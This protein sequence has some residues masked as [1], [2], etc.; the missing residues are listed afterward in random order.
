MIGK[1]FRS[2]PFIFANDNYTLSLPPQETGTGAA[3]QKAQAET[4]RAFHIQSVGI[5]EIYVP[6]YTLNLYPT[7]HIV[8]IY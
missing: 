6:S 2:L 3:L 4:T 5:S 8:S 7:P 1:R